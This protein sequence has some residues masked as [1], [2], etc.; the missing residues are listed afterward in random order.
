MPR[1]VG[2]SAIGGLSFEPVD[3]SAQEDKV[4]VEG[5]EQLFS[6]KRGRK[7]EVTW[8]HIWTLKDGLVVGLREYLNTAVYAT[9]AKA[10]RVAPSKAIA[11]G[12]GSN[13][14]WESKLWRDKDLSKPGFI[15]TV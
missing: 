2:T 3:F 15:I 6:K 1:L 5:Y 4:F 7:V 10:T 14:V 9:V 12:W 8:V 13:P 11:L